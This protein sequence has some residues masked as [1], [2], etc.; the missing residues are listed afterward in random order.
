M[1]P[2]LLL[3][4][5]SPALA[6]VDK[7]FG[8]SPELLSKYVSSSSGNWKCLDGSKEI[9]WSFVND[10]SCDCPD[11]SDEPEGTG[12]CPNSVFYCQNKGH[13]GAAIPSSRVNDGLCEPE[14]CDGSDERPGVCKNVCKETGEVYRAKRDEERKLRKTGSKIR[15]TYIQFA[16]KEKVRLENL[17]VSSAKDIEIREKE[18]AR[19]KDIAD[20]TESISKAALEHKQQSPLYVALLDHADALTAL[21]REHKKHL[22]REKA[23]GD[24]LHTLRSGYNPNYQDMAVLEAVRGWE[25]LS[26]LPHIGETEGGGAE[27]DVPVKEEEVVETNEDENAWTPERLTNELDTLLNGDYVSLLLEHDEHIRAPREDSLLFDL[28]LYLPESFIPQYEEIKEAIVSWLVKLGIVSGGDTA[29]AD[30][31]RA[32]QNLLDAE[33]AL[34]SATDEKKQAG[35]DLAEL[36][37]IHGFGR[38][39][40]WK[41]LDN[42]CLRTDQGD[43]TY[44]LCLFQEA[45]Q[46]PKNGGSTFSLGRFDSWNPAEN[47]EPGEPEYYKKQAYK[48]GARCWNGPERNVIASSFTIIFG[49][50]LMQPYLAS[51]FLRLGKHAFIRRGA[52]KLTNI[53]INIF[54]NGIMNSLSPDDYASVPLTLFDRL[55]ERTT[56]LTGWLVEGAIDTE[57]LATALSGVTKKWRMLSGRLESL[58]DEDDATQWR[59]RIPL[60]EIPEDY[61]TFAL[62]TS[63]S[64]FSLSHYVNSPLPLVSR[65]LPHALFIHP[66]T[67]RQYTLWESTS[68]PLTCWHVTHLPAGPSNGEKQHTCIG[69]ARSHGIFDGVGAAAVM[70][71]LVSEMRG[72]DWTAPPQPSSGFRDNTLQR[73]LG[74]RI[75][76]YKSSGGIA[77][78]DYHGFVDLG[79]AGAVKQIAWHVR[80]RWWS[81]AD[82]RI[83]LLPKDVLLFLTNSVRTELRRSPQGLSKIEVTTG[84]ILVAWVLKTVYSNGT[85]PKSVI[86]CLNLASFRSLLAEDDPTI[87]Q[88]PH[89]AFVPLPYPSMTVAQLKEYPLHELSH[90]LAASRSALAIPH[91]MSSYDALQS[92]TAFPANPAAH[93]NMVVSNVSASRILESDWSSIGAV[94]TLCGYRYQLTPNELLM[95]NNVYIAGRLDD[96]TVVLDVSLNKERVDLL[97]KEVFMLK[98]VGEQVGTEAA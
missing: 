42:H 75:E 46:I 96:G 92:V 39:G 59:I 15:S 67:P 60:G 36:F 17:I 50:F 65:S 98:A 44:E 41:K 22:E 82:R 87:P 45:K 12:A 30:S 85:S 93:E 3:L 43:Y 90:I 64:E 55:F 31:S 54:S 94:Q 27:D 70:R 71:A 79:V 76:E 18:V 62:T 68:H 37:N 91:L 89:N 23:L 20:R 38:D 2:W 69:F 10:D 52:G 74:A 35:E 95:T 51:S 8:V 34:K 5:I 56:F 81:G 63:T 4:S 80:E 49:G 72:E 84:D 19:L 21:Q 6:V 7:T 16:Q 83:L 58:Q 28:T 77:P 32:R 11:G 13:I 78:K 61:K 1:L 66:S 33:N 9:P 53:I 73:A 57:A 86:Q 14:C 25:E 24:I 40:E 48:H 29:S 97:A 47:V 88:Y 26:G